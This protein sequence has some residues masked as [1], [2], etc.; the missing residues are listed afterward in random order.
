MEYTAFTDLDTD[1]Q[2]YRGLCALHEHIFATDASRLI[3]E[4]LAARPRFL[5]LLASDEARVVGYKIGY[6]ERGKEFYSW[7]G[8]V[9]SSYRGQGIA[10]QLMARQHAWCREQGYTV[11]ST[12]TKNKWRNMLILNLRHGFDI[13]G[14]Y[15]DDQGE[16][17]I[18][19]TKTLEL[20]DKKQY[21]EESKCRSTL[22]T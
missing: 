17:K 15:T 12:R 7:L 13:I 6:E 5:I 3:V 19:L 1:A 20:Q 22:S 16:P 10:S 21:G 8:G 2:W 9:D 14:T 4:R 18:I 11:V